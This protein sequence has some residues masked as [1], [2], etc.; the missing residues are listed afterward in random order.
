[1][2]KGTKVYLRDCYDHTVQYQP[3]GYLA[4]MLFMLGVACFQIYYFKKK[5]WF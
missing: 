4:V 3:Y 1:V 5:R 2:T